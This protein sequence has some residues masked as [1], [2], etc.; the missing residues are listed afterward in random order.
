MRLRSGGNPTRLLHRFG[1]LDPR[2]MSCPPRTFESGKGVDDGQSGQHHLLCGRSARTGALLV[3]GA[4]LSAVGMRRT[5]EERADRG[6][7]V[8]RGPRQARTGRG[9]RGSGAAALLPPRLE[10]EGR[11]QPHPPRCAGSAVR[12]SH[13]RAAGRGEGP[14]GGT[15]RPSRPP[16]R[17]VLGRVGRT[18][19]SAR[20]SRGKRV[21][22]AVTGQS[23]AEEAGSSIGTTGQ[24]FHRRS[25][26]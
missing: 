13:P 17:S 5:P 4:R 16:G 6:R 19:L 22:P 9:P 24:S 1:C 2:P 11:S 21:L 10:R 12:I 14:A 15:W 18:L 7:P 25:R 3:W 23:T 20:G 8:R 26:P